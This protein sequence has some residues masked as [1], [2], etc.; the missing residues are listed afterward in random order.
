MRS[1]LV[2]GYEQAVLAAFSADGRQLEAPHAPHREDI[3]GVGGLV[4]GLQRQVVDLHTARGDIFC[5]AG[6]GGV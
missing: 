5:R 6:A 4:G 1:V 2:K 3:L